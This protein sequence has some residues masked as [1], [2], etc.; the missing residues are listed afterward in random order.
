MAYSPEGLDDALAGVTAGAGFASLH[1]ADPG[2]TGDG[3]DDE[4]TLLPLTWATPNG[5]GSVDATEVP[6]VVPEGSGTRVYVGFGLWDGDDPGTATYK[7]GGL[8]DEEETF[9]NNG[10]TYNFTPTLT[11]ATAA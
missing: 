11:A 6:F 9:S 7:A 10:G 1:L 4:V 2:S 3:L 8:L 5:S